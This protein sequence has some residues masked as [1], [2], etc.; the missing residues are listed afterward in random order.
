MEKGRWLPE[1]GCAPKTS[2]SDYLALELHSD[3]RIPASL[4]MNWHRQ[5]T[6]CGQLTCPVPAGLPQALLDPFRNRSTSQGKHGVKQR[7]DRKGPVRP[8]M[9][10]VTVKAA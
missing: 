6:L 5:T 1:V 3:L 4:G 9:L 7:L 10:L 2:Q 8:Q